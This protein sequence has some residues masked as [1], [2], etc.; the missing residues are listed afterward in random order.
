MQHW[1]WRGKKQIISSMSRDHHLSDNEL[2]AL[3]HSCI[4]EQIPDDFRIYL[5]PQELVSKVTTSLLKLPSSMQSPARNTTE[6]QAHYWGYWLKYLKTIE[7]SDNLCLSSFSHHQKHCIISGFGAAVQANNVQ[8]YP[9]ASSASAPVSSTV[10]ATF[11]DVAQSYWVNDNKSLI[12]NA[13]RKLAI[14][15]Q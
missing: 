9:G 15:L 13:D 14:I 4:A 5:L 11:D 8:D 6:K 7:L 3:L 10:R 1:A 12:H 2:L